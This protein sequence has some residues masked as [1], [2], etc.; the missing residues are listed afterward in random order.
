MSAQVEKLTVTTPAYEFASLTP[1][2]TVQ[3]WPVL[4]PIIDRALEND[5]DQTTSHQVLG[6]I[7]VNELTLIVV[8]K[9]GKI[10][11]AMTIEYVNFKEKICHCMT[12]SGD[13]M[14]GWVDEF[15]DIWRKLGAEIGCRYL[16]IKG[17]KGWQRYAKRFGFKHA[18]TQM[19]IDLEG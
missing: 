9:D 7:L 6:K 11:A 8:Q 12:F 19:Y 4:G 5:Y 17:R 10:I 13:D 16:S 2:Q 18:Y 1:Q 3:Y 15:I 14:E